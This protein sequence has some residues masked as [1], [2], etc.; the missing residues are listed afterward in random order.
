MPLTG[1]LVSLSRQVKLSSRN[2]GCD[3]QTHSWWTRRGSL[4]SDVLLA[5]ILL[6]GGGV[7]FAQQPQPRHNCTVGIESPSE[8]QSVSPEGD[9]EGTATVPAGKFLWVLARRRGLHDWWPQGGGAAQIN[10]GSWQV[11]VTYG[12]PLDAGHDFDIAATVV[13]PVENTRLDRWVQTANST[14]RYPPVVFP[15]A[16]VGCPIAR[17]TVHRAE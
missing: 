13:E 12:A 7:A 1:P 15:T 2:E 4:M 16:A 5:S 9:V 6:A 14:G 17:L 10:Q 3:M 11:P 8:G